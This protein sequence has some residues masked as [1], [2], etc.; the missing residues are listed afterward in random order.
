MLNI[1]DLM[2]SMLSNSND[3]NHIESFFIEAASICK[4]IDTSKIH[5]L[6]QEL[7]QLRI[8]S[9]RLFIL[10]VGGGA[11][12]ASHACNDFRKLCGIEAYCPSDNV[13]EL[14]ARAN[15]EGWRTVFSGYLKTSQ[16]SSNDALFIMSVGGGSKE[17][18]I[19]ENIIEAIDLA[20][21]VK[22]NIYGITG[23]NAG[24][25]AKNATLC[26][27]IPGVNPR[28]ITPHCESM[29]MVILHAL[30]S[31]PWLQITDTKW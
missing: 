14:T 22:A 18:G 20:K 3:K 12:N 16:L 23:R 19:S 2:R 28:H 25:L 1:L 7:V 10:G 13:A 8:N 27:Q 5:E 4:K 30:V 11:A 26:I 17:R 6:V 9:G 15:D 29:Q 31:H 21:E 24:Y